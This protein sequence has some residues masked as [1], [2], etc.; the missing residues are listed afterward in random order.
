MDN[1]GINFYSNYDKCII[2]DGVEARWKI[3]LIKM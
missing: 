2:Q 3:I 1:I